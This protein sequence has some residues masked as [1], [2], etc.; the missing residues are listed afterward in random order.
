MKIKQAIIVVSAAAAGLLMGYAVRHLTGRSLSETQNIALSH[1]N[2]VSTKANVGQKF[3]D[4]P[5][6]TKL[7]HDLSISSGVTRWL[8]WWQAIERAQLADMPRLARLANGDNTAI[9]LVA[10]RWI[11]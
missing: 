6:A 9:R 11:E 4:S 10:S 5:L 1:N 7:E 8:C 2:K 3:D